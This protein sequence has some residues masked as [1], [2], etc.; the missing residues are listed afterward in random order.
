MTDTNNQRP[1][2]S[3]GDGFHLIARGLAMLF[4]AQRNREDWIQRRYDPAFEGLAIAHQ[5]EWDA[6]EILTGVLGGRAEH[7][8]GRPLGHGVHRSFPASEREDRALEIIGVLIEASGVPSGHVLDAARTM[9]ADQL[10]VADELM[11]AARAEGDDS[12]KVQH[13]DPPKDG[14]DDGAPAQAWLADDEDPD[15]DGAGESFDPT[16][17]LADREADTQ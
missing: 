1:R 9:L 15:A 4:A 8:S 2:L 16:A 17:A 7:R 11:E 3:R 5:M 10:H 13:Q 14:E 6:R 12:L